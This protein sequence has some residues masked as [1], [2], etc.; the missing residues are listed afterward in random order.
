LQHNPMIPLWLD[1]AIEK[2]VRIDH[3]LRYDSFS[4]FNHDLTHPNELFMKNTLPLV[5]KDPLIFWRS[6]AA[7]LFILNFFMLYLLLK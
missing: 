2:A 7:V 3:R 6:I 1:G 4:E 5:E